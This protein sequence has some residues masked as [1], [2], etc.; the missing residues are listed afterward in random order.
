MSGALRSGVERLS[1]TCGSGTSP[2]GECPADPEPYHRALTFAPNPGG[3]AGSGPPAS[4]QA[5]SA[6]ARRTSCDRSGAPD[7]RTRQSTD[8]VT[9]TTVTSHRP[10]GSFP[11]AASNPLLPHT[12]SP[13]LRRP[14]PDSTTTCVDRGELRSLRDR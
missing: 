11:H 1:I 13:R 8:P 2:K 9:T 5:A 14:D 6:L 7:P 3:A 10:G 4:S 12:G